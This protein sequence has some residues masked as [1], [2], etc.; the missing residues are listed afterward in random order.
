MRGEGEKGGSS[1]Y[2]PGNTPYKIKMGVIVT[3]VLLGTCKG[4]GAKKRLE[5]F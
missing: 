1:S 5:L 2:S 3:V 4:Y